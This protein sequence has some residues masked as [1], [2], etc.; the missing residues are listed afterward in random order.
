MMAV[1]K[2]PTFEN[3]KNT[4]SLFR[5]PEEDPDPAGLPEKDQTIVGS[6]EDNKVTRGL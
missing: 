3:F 4:F 1:K 6:D 2:A 5:V